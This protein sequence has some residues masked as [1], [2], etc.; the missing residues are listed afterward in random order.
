MSKVKVK[1]GEVIKNFKNS[2]IY[3]GWFDIGMQHLNRCYEG[4]LDQSDTRGLAIIGESGTGKTSLINHFVSTHPEYRDKEGAKVHIVSA[5]VPPKPTVKGLA[6]LILFYLGDPLFDKGTESSKTLRLIT[7]LKGAST[8]ML[9]LDE[10]QHFVDQGSSKI[11]HHVADWLKMVVDESE[12]CLVVTGLP[13][14]IHVIQT[15]SQLK[16]RI[17]KPILLPRFD[18]M[19]DSHREQFIAIIDAMRESMTGMEF[20][21]LTDEGMAFRFYCATGGLIG[22]LAN[23]FIEVAQN[24][25][26]NKKWGI[27]L[28]ALKKAANDASYDLLNDMINPFDKKASTEATDEIISMVKRIGIKEEMEPNRIIRRRKASI[29][30]SDALKK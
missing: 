9:V 6:E 1:K 23:L 25:F 24:A 17:Q 11:Q 18:W 3:H 26:D 20:P 2:M 14:C 22:R 29:S 16:R 7:L 19:I 15:N 13:Y 21:D 27:T 28:P 4:A 10:F 5:M 30:V 8:K 12:V